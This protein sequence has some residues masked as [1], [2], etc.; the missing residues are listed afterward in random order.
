L[1]LRTLKIDPGKLAKQ[2][3]Q[4]VI[5]LPDFSQTIFGKDGARFE[6]P[7]YEYSAGFLFESGSDM[8]HWPGLIRS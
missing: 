8:E 4:S 3:R 6:N 1:F 7:P 2:W 5:H